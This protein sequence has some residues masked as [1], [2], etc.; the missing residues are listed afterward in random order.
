MA[1]DLQWHDACHATRAFTSAESAAGWPDTMT[2]SQLVAM[3]RPFERGDK[4]GRLA[5][6]ALAAA[7]LAACKAGE[8]EHSTETTAV[9]PPK[10]RYKVVQTNNGDPFS[11]KNWAARGFNRQW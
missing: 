8:L 10:P 4:A 11:S 2:L 6:R 1:V 3:Q 5:Q 7:L 9:Q